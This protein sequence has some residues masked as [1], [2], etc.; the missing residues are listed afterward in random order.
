PQPFP[1]LQSQPQPQPHPSPQPQPQPHVINDDCIPMIDT[2]F[3][4]GGTPSYIESRHIRRILNTLSIYTE[5]HG[6][7]QSLSSSNGELLHCAKDH[8][9]NSANKQLLNSANGQL[10][11]GAKDQTIS[12]AN[13]QLLHDPNGQIINSA[14]EQLLHSANGQ[15]PY[16]D[17]RRVECTLEA[18]PGTLSEEKLAEYYA[19]G[20]N[21]LS[22][23]LQSIHEDQLRLLGRIHSFKDFKDNIMAARRIGFENIS[24][25]VIFGIPGQSAESWEQTLATVVESGVKHISCYSLSLEKGTRLHSMIENKTIVSPDEEL[26]RYMYHYALE[27]LK[28]SGFVHYEISNFA[29]PG[30]E[31]RHNMK[32]WTCGE[33][34]GFGA[35]ASSHYKSVRYTNDASITDYINKINKNG[36]A[37]NA[38]QSEILD[39]AEKMKE[40]IILRLRLCEGV[41]TGEFEARFNL[42]FFA[43]YG[44]SVDKLAQEDLL[45][46]NKVSP[47][48]DH[49][50]IRLTKKGLDFANLVFMEFI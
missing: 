38:S 11:H 24:A 33:Y 14:N 15:P 42:G 13:E 48:C 44:N 4:G 18:N 43:M 45:S 35:G 25:D 1:S 32:Y 3:I 20:I 10:L 37:V 27:F 22:F 8:S 49:S 36:S 9:L 40:H 30:Y 41:H 5:S 21:R 16:P 6:L 12:S 19:M 47:H 2:V 39:K 23:G 26:D 50:I 29:Q 34:L 28:K 46:V 7:S 17:M 31:C